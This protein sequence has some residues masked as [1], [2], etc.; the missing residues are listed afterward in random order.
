MSLISIS[1]KEKQRSSNFFFG[2]WNIP[3]ILALFKTTRYSLRAQSCSDWAE[4][5]NAE[6]FRLQVNSLQK[7]T[8][9]FRR[10]CMKEHLPEVSGLK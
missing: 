7:M 6:D 10:V 2:G 5:W 9:T 8:G 1:S 4:H 3:I